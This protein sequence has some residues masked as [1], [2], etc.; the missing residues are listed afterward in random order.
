VGPSFTESNVEEVRVR[1]SRVLRATRLFVQTGGTG[2]VTHTEGRTLNGTQT[3]FLLN[4]EPL[5]A[6]TTVIENGSPLAIGGG[7]WTYNSTLKAIVRASGGT[8]GHAISVQY[9]VE[10]PAWVRVWDSSV[11]AAAG[12]WVTASL[13]DAIVE[14]SEQ[15]D[16]AQAKAWGDAE[17][18]RRFLQ[19][20]VVTFRTRVKGVYPLLQCALTFPDD[21]ISGD[22]LVQSVRATAFDDTSVVYSVTAIEGDTLRRN[23][24]DFFKGS[25]SSSSG[26]ITVSGTSGSSGSTAGTVAPIRI[27]LGGDNYFSDNPTD[28]TDAPNAVPVQLGGPGLAGTWTLRAFRRLKSVTTPNATTIELRLRDATNAVTLASVTGTSATTFAG[29]TVTFAMPLTPGVCL[30]QYRMVISSGTPSEGVVGQCSLERD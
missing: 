8:N 27:P 28:W 13:V 10:F 11:Q 18:A 15:T 30:L 26:G 5:E 23:W 24:F 3:T 20:K 9:P 22:Y 19:P 7:T 4:V 2:T 14:A 12:T 1:Q 16:L 6:P 25:A 29:T 17:L 21:G